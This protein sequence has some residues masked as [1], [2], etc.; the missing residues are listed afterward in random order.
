MTRAVLMVLWGLVAF[1]A[2]E[3]LVF[4]P[5]YLAGLPA[6]WLASR[7]ARTVRRPSR[8][9]PERLVLCY[10]S[11]LLDAWLGNW[12]DGLCPEWWASIGGTPFNWWLR[13][14]VCNLRFAPILSTLPDPA[15]VRYVGADHMPE[16]GE[17][18]WFVCWQDGY[19]GML[20]Q[21]ASWGLWIGWKVKPEDQLGVPPDSCRNWG[22]GVAAQLMR[23]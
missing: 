19:V 12:E 21:C 15:R 4:L 22:I 16:P 8:L 20:W 3:V 6:A 7:Y 9:Y 23:F 2:V 17:P 10:E 13:N 11:Q 1:L 14:P 5:L 18:G